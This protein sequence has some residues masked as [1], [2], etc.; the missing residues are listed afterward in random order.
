MIESERLKTLEEVKKQLLDLQFSKP[1]IFQDLGY[2][3]TSTIIFLVFQK[4]QDLQLD[5]Y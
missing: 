3:W 4:R 5:E 1:I 2:G